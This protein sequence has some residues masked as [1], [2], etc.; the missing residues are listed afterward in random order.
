M[1]PKIALTLIACGTAC[2]LA[3]I[4]IAAY[5]LKQLSPLMLIADTRV[6]DFHVMM[7]LIAAIPATAVFVVGLSMIWIG[8][9]RSTIPTS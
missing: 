1:N 3:P 4:A 8:L 2:V 7:I 5:L 6:S 9:R